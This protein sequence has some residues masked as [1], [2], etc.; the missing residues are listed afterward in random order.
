LIYDKNGQ[1][2]KILLSSKTSYLLLFFYF[3]KNA[4]LKK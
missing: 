1:K 2:H 3:A 4:E